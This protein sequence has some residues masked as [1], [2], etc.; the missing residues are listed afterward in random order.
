MALPLEEVADRGGFAP[1]R[2]VIPP[3]GPM[4]ALPCADATSDVRRSG[5]SSA[6]RW[7]RNVPEL[8]PAIRLTAPIVAPPARHN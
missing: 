5:D 2:R 3:A 6:K 7:R 4:I 8:R 1:D